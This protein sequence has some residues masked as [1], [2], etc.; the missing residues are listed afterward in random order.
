M[1]TTALFLILSGLALLAGISRAAAA[2]PPADVAYYTCA[3]HP[4]VHLLDP[5]AKCPICGMNVVPVMKVSATPPADTPPS[6][7][8]PRE[9]TIPLE[10]QQ[11]IGVTYAT[12]ESRPLRR[13]LRAAGVVAAP[14]SA[15]RDCVARVDGYV[16]DLDISAPGDRVAR[17]Q[18]LMDIYSPD[19]VATESEYVDLLRMREK[20]LRDN[21]A[22]ATEVAGRLLAGARARLEQWNVTD[23]QIDAIGKAGAA[24]RYLPLLAPVAGTV[25]DIAVRQGARVAA[26]DRLATLVDLSSVWVWADFHEDELPLIKPGV[27]VT[28]TSTSLP[29]WSLPG[30]IAVMDPFINQMK[31]TGRVRIDVGNAALK[32]RPEA[33]VDVAVTLDAGEGLAVPVDAV[34][35]TGGRDIVFVDK[36]A[37]RLEPRFI[38]I[39]GKF[40]GFYQVTAGL[41][42]GERVV[43]SGNFLVDAESKI[44]GALKD[45]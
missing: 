45:F 15:R 17:G 5:D 34:L 40:G 1:K 24:A 25:E 36:G 11:L 39:G 16:H 41:S 31:R 37:G 13:V 3:M 29:G 21:D 26:G 14:T 35:P 6:A 28:I 19:L 32:L 43:A 18:V 20:A 30:T 7:D 4:S 38:R 12:V 10:R 33:Y 9:F 2:T 44:E 23:G 42:A 22:P 8:Q 27:A